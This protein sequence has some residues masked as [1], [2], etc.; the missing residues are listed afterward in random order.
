[1]LYLKDC[2]WAFLSQWQCVLCGHPKELGIHLCAVVQYWSP[3]H[4]VMRKIGTL[5][6][7]YHCSKRYKTTLFFVL[8]IFGSGS[9]NAMTGGRTIIDNLVQKPGRQTAI[10][11]WVSEL[12]LCTRA[13]SG[14]SPCQKEKFTQFPL[15]VIDMTCYLSLAFVCVKLWLKRGQKAQGLR[16]LA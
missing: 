13:F 2:Q 4:S 7:K 8:P 9:S 5:W 11:M 14:H 3:V 16:K 12:V 6:S 10:I 1:M 15:C